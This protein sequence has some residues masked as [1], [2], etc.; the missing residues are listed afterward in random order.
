MKYP[1]ICQRLKGLFSKPV[2]GGRSM[3]RL[4]ISATY[5]KIIICSYSVVKTLIGY[6]VSQ[7]K[8]T[9]VQEGRPVSSEYDDTTMSAD[10]EPINGI[11][12]NIGWTLD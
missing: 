7:G 6:V 1:K 3:T 5:P 12:I 9:Y 2:N 8:Y 10:L 11:P 4:R